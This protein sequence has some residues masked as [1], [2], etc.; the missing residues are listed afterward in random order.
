MRTY[1]KSSDVSNRLLNECLRPNSKELAEH[2][3]SG[4]LTCVVFEPDESNAE[5]AKNL[6]WDGI[7]PVFTM[8]NAKREG[9]AKALVDTDIICSTWLREPP[10]DR[11]F[12]LIKHGLL[13]VN[14]DREKQLYLLVDPPE[15]AMIN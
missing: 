1:L 2:M 9:L 5:A 4:Q 11:L 8:S 3:L 12:V 13:L 14:Y 7:T 6:G 10:F 15:E